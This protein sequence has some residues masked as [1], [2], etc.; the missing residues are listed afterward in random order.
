MLSMMGIN[1]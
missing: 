1:A